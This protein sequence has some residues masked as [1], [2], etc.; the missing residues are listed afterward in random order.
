M[1]VEEE[2]TVSNQDLTASQHKLASPS[3]ISGLKLNV[4]IVYFFFSVPRQ[5]SCLKVGN[6]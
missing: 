5:L 1:I 2:A 3:C 6:V 4:S